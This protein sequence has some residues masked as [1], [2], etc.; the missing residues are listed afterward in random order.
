MSCFC[1]GGFRGLTYT[2][3]E[4]GCQCVRGKELHNTV[5]ERGC[6]CIRGTE[7]HIQSVR[8]DVSVL[9]VKNYIYSQ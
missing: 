3:S 6:Q 5:S 4:R 9:E 1:L 7:L 8:G 2:V